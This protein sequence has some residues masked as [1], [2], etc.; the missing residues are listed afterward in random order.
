MFWTAANMGVFAKTNG[1]FASIKYKG[2]IL[3]LVS[4]VEEL[5]PDYFFGAV[6]RYWG[7][8]FAVI[9]RIA[10]RDLKKSKTYFEKS[11]SMAPEFLGTKVIQAE[12]YFVEDDDK[13]GFKK[14]LN[15]V[16][17]D[18]AFDQHLD[19][20]PENRMEKIKARRLLEKLDDL[21]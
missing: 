12:T 11:I 5:K 8:Y 2:K 16:L 20:G 21:F 9:P 14:V 10:G 7:S 19:V 13:D 6:P 17:Q 3:A 15:S 1:I 18:S 4:R